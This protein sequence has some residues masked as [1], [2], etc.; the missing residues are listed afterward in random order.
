MV[1]RSDRLLTGVIMP[2]YTADIIANHVVLY[3]RHF[4]QKPFSMAELAVKLQ[5]VLE[6]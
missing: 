6:S 2:E 3:E 5:E 1:E 4:I